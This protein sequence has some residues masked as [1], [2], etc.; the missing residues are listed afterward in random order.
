MITVD[1]TR[2]G[3]LRPRDTRDALRA[4]EALEAG[5]LA[6]PS[7]GRQVGHY[8]L[9]SLS[10]HGGEIE[11]MHRLIVSLPVQS[12][13]ELVVCGIGGS[14]LGPQ[15]LAD[16]L[17]RPGLRPHFL[18]NTDPAG[19][20][21]VLDE[22]HLERALVL[23]VSKSGGT[24]E[25]RNAWAEVLAR[26]VD[27]ARQAIA[28]TV[29]GS[30]LHAQ[31]Q[32]WLA[33]VPLWDWVGGRTSI[34]SAVGLLPMQLMG[35]DWRALLA[36]ARAMDEQ[37]RG[38]DNVALR[39]ACAWL[40]ASPRDMVVLPYRDGLQTFARYL[41]QLVMESLGKQGQGLTVYGNKG[42][43]D[44]HA[45][46]QQLRDGPDTFF[47]TFL[48]VLGG[49]RGAEV[50]PG[51]HTGDYL[52]GFLIG[53]RNALTG[54]GRKSLTITWDE[55][56]AWHLGGLIALYERAVGYAA[57]LMG[58]NAYDQPGVEAGKKAA[59]EALEWL[60]SLRAGQLP[61]GLSPDDRA[62]LEGWLSASR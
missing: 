25:T 24:K 62:L 37:T 36:G 47:A 3:P 4:M 42:S 32:G 26:G 22:V 16:A 31:A 40:D 56:D 14:A 10:L 21:R 19:I 53:T 27:P 5:A 60:S 12:F 9:R 49:P 46:V 18:D 52:Q 51:I 50:E 39:L 54:A 30:H 33:R 7:E 29:P 8:W 2:M 23:V 45:Y 20:A 17:P 35:Q 48:T 13:T 59:A 28:V 41:Q 34:T 11:A 61:E 55:L 1:L 38:P 6:N 58:V 44:Q 43:T 57:T 15:L